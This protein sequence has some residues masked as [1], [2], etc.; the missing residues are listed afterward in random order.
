MHR[1]MILRKRLVAVARKCV[2]FIQIK[3]LE[4]YLVVDLY[5]CLDAG[6]TDDAGLLREHRIVEAGPAAE[7]DSTLKTDN[8]F[9]LRNAALA[10]PILPHG[11]GAGDSLNH[12]ASYGECPPEVK[13]AAAAMGIEYGMFTCRHQFNHRS[14]MQFSR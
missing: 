14:N 13:M 1:S 9:I 3:I 2:S 10:G 7:T 12:L 4:V 8:A 11:F 5:H 6:G